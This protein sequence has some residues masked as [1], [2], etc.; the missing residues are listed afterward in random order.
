MV[1]VWVGWLAETR[2]LVALEWR[3]FFFC[4]E[5]ASQSH[6]TAARGASCYFIIWLC[7][8]RKS[9]SAVF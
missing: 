2:R 1:C 7:M 4:Y 9:I 6:W 8:V 3:G 5:R